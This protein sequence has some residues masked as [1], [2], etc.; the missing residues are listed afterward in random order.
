M[1]PQRMML[2]YNAPAPERN[3]D[4]RYA[5]G[6][7]AWQSHSLPLGNGYFGANIF[8]RTEVERIQISEPSLVNPW[9]KVPK[10]I[11]G[12]PAAGVN[13]FAELY[14]TLDHTSP[15]QILSSVEGPGEFSDECGI[16][17]T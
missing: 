9:L 4:A 13:S 17:E 11:R 2:R 8:G 1:K 3:E 14:V 12:C 5:T 15:A 6:E 10:G 7:D 16:S